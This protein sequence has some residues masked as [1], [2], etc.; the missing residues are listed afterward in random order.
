M[1]AH[2]E[3]RGSKYVYKRGFEKLLLGKPCKSKSEAC[4]HEYQIKQLSR[5][6]KLDWFKKLPNCIFF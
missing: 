3:G 6:Q 4:K 1:K 2:V 5:N